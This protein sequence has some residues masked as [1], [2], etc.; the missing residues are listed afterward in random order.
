MEILN[1][2][3]VSGKGAAF[4]FLIFTIAAICYTFAFFNNDSVILGSV[5]AVLSIILMV[6]TI[7]KFNA[8]PHTRYEVSFDGDYTV[9]EL[10]ENYEIIGQRGNILIVEEKSE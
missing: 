4:V 3:Q 1:T 7:V 8:P 5:T 9:S 10:I 2:V 6:C